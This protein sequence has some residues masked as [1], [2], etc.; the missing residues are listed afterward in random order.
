MLQEWR[1][2]WGVWRRFIG[3]RHKNPDDVEDRQGSSGREN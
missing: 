2:S 3:R 1:G